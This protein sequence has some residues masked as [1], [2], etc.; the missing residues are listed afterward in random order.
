MRGLA[1]KR[2][3]LDQRLAAD[4]EAAALRAAQPLAAAEKHQIGAHLGEAPQVL[5][6]GQL[7]GRVHHQRNAM[8]MGD[9][10]PFF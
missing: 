7:G 8:A 5:D 4:N 3:R 2:N 9:G 10:N 6:R 1:L